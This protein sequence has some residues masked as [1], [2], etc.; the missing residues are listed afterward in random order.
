[1][2][3]NFIYEVNPLIINFQQHIQQKLM[4]N[5]IPRYRIVLGE[6]AQMGK[7]GNF[8]Y[9]QQLYLL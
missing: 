8:T 4:Y 9:Y 6:K 1:M 2:I 5:K 7:I 3:W